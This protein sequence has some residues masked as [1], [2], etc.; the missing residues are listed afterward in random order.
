MLKLLIVENNLDV[1]EMLVNYFVG[2]PSGS[3]EVDTAHS[4]QTAL[5]GLLLDGSFDLVITTNH[6]ADMMGVELFAK[7]KEMFPSMPVILT[8][9]L[10]IK[11]LPKGLDAFYQKPFDIEEL[12][13]AV[14]RLT[15]KKQPA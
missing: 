8:S 5:N 7:I 11:P 1:L 9:G 3:Y 14:E 2:G 13:C 12:G 10:P 15:T 4:G 6:L